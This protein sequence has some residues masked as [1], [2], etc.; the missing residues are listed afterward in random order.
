MDWQITLHWV[1]TIIVIEAIVEV[2]HDSDLF[3]PLLDFL[4]RRSNRVLN[5]FGRLLSCGYCFSVWVSFAA[6]W[7]LGPITGVLWLDIILKT[8]LLHRLS[9]IFH[10]LIARWFNHTPFVMLFQTR[11]PVDDVPE[12]PFGTTEEDGNAEEGDL[13]RVRATEDAGTVQD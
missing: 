9:N 2:V 3:F 1:I 12:D 7:T 11:H 8:F 13:E 6:S 5:F 10:E 4:H